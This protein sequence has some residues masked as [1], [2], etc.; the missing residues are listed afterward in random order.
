VVRVDKGKDTL[1]AFDKKI[2]TA[3]SF[4]QNYINKHAAF[5]SIGGLDSSR[6][7]I[8]EKADVPA[9]LVILCKYF[10]IPNKRAFN[11]VNQDRGQAIKGSAIMGFSLDLQMCLDEA[12]EDLC[13]MGCAVFEKQC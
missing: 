7:P 2:V 5:F 12:A 13:H 10:D 1:A 8:K 6:P 11:S 4:L 3:L 9:F